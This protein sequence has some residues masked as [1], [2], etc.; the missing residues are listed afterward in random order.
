VVT[1]L[2][3]RPV[4]P[5]HPQP[6]LLMLSGET[7]QW[8]SSLM[9]QPVH[10]IFSKQNRQTALPGLMQ[11]NAKMRFKLRIRWYRKLRKRKHFTEDSG[12]EQQPRVSRTLNE[13]EI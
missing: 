13:T 6:P 9:Y 11:G 5:F 8:E 3:K 4:V 10:V 7:L 1:K 12:Q 2:K